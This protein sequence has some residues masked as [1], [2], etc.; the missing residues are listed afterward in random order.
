[1]WWQASHDWPQIQ[2]TAV[3]RDDADWG[4]RAGLL[5]NDFINVNNGT[6]TPH[7]FC[8][9]ISSQFTR[10]EI[11]MRSRKVLV[12]I[13]AGA[14]PVMAQNRPM[15]GAPASRLFPP[16]KPGRSSAFHGC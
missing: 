12:S 7:D 1:M 14:Q 13:I 15:V 16:E 10:E 4:G 5:P 9:A 3:I 11:E 6:T 8:H 2:L